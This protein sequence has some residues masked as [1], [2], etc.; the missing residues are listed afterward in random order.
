MCATMF[1]SIFTQNRILWLNSFKDIKSNVYL[2]QF[3]RSINVTKDLPN[4]KNTISG[5]KSSI[6]Q[7]ITKWFTCSNSVNIDDLIRPHHLIRSG[8]LSRHYIV[9]IF[10]TSSWSSWPTLQ[11]QTLSLRPRLVPLQNQFFQVS[12]LKFW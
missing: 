4:I 1:W 2:V 10:V 3:I 7:L 8:Y 12:I 9:N 11:L 6:N 5:S